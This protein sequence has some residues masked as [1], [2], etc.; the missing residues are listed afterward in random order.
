MSEE[1]EIEVNEEIAGE[2]AQ[3]QLPLNFI[4][5]GDIGHDDIKVYIRQSVYKELERYALAD[6]E[7]ERGT[8]LLGQSCT[9]S[10]KTNVVISDYIEAKYTDA[11][12][13]TLTFTHETWDYV[14][15]QREKNFPKERIVGWQ[16]THPNYGIF[17][18]NYDLFIQEN[19]F[20]L[21]FQIAYV[22]DPVQQLRGFFQWKN[23]KIGKLGGYYIYDEVGKVIKIPQ[24]RKPA[25]D[26]KGKSR[27][28]IGALI[29]AAAFT[30]GNAAFL[31]ANLRSV[32]RNEALI[33]EYQERN[34]Q[35]QPQEE[36]PLQPAEE[37]DSSGLEKELAEKQ[38]RIEAQSAQIAE[39]EAQTARLR[40]IE[41]LYGELFF[42]YQVKEGDNLWDICQ[43]YRIDY[44]QKIH[45]IEQ[46]NR[47]TDRGSLWPG[48]T[49]ILP[50][51]ETA[52]QE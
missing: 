36:P 51:G 8:I 35:T 41:E 28:K 3:L 14:H 12:A 49:L 11:S 21:P 16:H 30:I 45:Q 39:L 5:V 22:I 44:A 38:E 19:F 13:S 34:Q 23:G 10:G 42:L 15:R 26:G 4:T 52:N 2:E 7:H 25:S 29:L 33:A 31:A 40:I 17:L 20:N 9:Y 48:Q 50:L 6:T 32:R 37:A 24:T 18:S 47:L 43:K 27:V 46:I 1:F